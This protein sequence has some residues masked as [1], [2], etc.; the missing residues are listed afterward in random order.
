MSDPPDVPPKGCWR[1]ELPDSSYL[2]TLHLFLIE[3]LRKKDMKNFINDSGIDG[4]RAPF[5]DTDYNHIR[6][7]HHLDFIIAIVTVRSLAWPRNK[8]LGSIYWSIARLFLFS[9]ICIAIYV[10][11][12][13]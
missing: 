10:R 8:G 5:M 13:L 6:Q 4:C 11:G 9:T 3:K 2:A 1:P 7:I 12:F